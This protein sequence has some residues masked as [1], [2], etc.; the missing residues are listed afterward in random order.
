MQALADVTAGKLKVESSVV[1]PFT[2]DP[3]VLVR[4]YAMF[5]LGSLKADAYV[6]LLEAGLTDEESGVRIAAAVALGKVNGPDSPKRM[7]AALL[8]DDKFQMRLACVGALAAMKERA[9]PAL[10]EGLNS[11]SPWVRDV[12]VRVFAA[13]APACEPNPPTQ[14]ERA[15]CVPVPNRDGLPG[16][17]A[18]LLTV[19]QNEKEDLPLFFAI[20]ALAGYR[21]PQVITTLLKS[22]RRGTPKVQ[23][24]VTQS[25]TQ[26]TSAMT[27]EQRKEML[28]SLIVLFREFGDGSKRSDAAWGW[29][30]VGNAMLACGESGREKLEAM[31]TERLGADQRQDGWLSWVAYQVLYVP[32]TPD[33][34]TLCTE[35]EAVESHEKYATPFPGW[36]A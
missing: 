34:A 19:L 6:P 28:D 9:L 20:N 23:M 15:P 5:A 16:A 35:E 7:M 1:A 3:H 21:T 17:Q 32:G 29:R 18:A 31:R 27:A 13:E 25:L 8:K 4:R 10:L 22:L 12:C 36:R 30:V 14:A 33:R 2:H 11:P 24:W 26:M